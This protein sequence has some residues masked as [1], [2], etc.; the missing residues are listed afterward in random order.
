MPELS[1]AKRILDLQSWIPEKLWR[2]PTYTHSIKTRYRD[3][4]I[5]LTTLTLKPKGED[6]IV[7]EARG[8]RPSAV[9]QTNMILEV[10]RADTA[11]I[12]HPV[13]VAWLKTLQLIILVELVGIFE[14]GWAERPKADINALAKLLQE[15]PIMDVRDKADLRTAF[16]YLRWQRDTKPLFREWWRSRKKQ[17]AERRK[18]VLETLK[19]HPNRSEVEPHIEYLLRNFESYNGKAKRVDQALATILQTWIA[20]TTGNQYETIKSQISRGK[21]KLEQLGGYEGLWPEQLRKIT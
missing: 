5:G 13:V 16:Q 11:F 12:A 10:V 4:E 19:T 9:H 2:S 8:P 21:K 6:D 18:A 3:L 15:A 17:P 7:W 14:T 20:S 1:T